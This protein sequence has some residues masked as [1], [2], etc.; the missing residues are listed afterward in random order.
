[1]GI[2]SP[3]FFIYLIEKNTSSRANENSITAFE[4]IAKA[5]YPELQK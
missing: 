3:Y 2:S 4:N 1:M 5:L